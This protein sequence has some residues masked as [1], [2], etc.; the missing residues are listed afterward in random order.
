MS[1]IPL[2][3]ILVDIRTRSRNASLFS[4]LNPCIQLPVIFFG[5]GHPRDLCW[6]HI[7]LLEPTLTPGL[8]S[9]SWVYGF[10]LFIQFLTLD[11]YTL[12]FG[13]LDKFVQLLVIC[14]CKCGSHASDWSRR[15]GGSYSSSRSS[16]HIVFFGWKLS[17]LDR[18]FDECIRYRTS[19]CIVAQ[20]ICYDVIGL[21]LQLD[22]C[23]A[24]CLYVF[25]I[26]RP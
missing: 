23:A 15:T 14:V 26:T 6:L 18:L 17:I 10:E 12:C 7:E 5:I 20:V 16:S 8:P 1:R 11:G 9:V 2:L 21:I 25:D 24:I 4:V 22:Y 19:R 13:I 3:K